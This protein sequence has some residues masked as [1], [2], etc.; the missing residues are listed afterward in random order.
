LILSY[1]AAQATHR[2]PI[3]GW[4]SGGSSC[5]SG[6]DYYTYINAAGF[7]F[8]VPL[9]MRG[10]QSDHIQ[11][12]RMLGTKFKLSELGRP[13]DLRAIVQYD[14][15][16]VNY[17]S[18]LITEN[19]NLY[20][21]LSPCYTSPPN[22]T[23]CWDDD[24][25]HSIDDLEAEGGLLSSIVGG[26]LVWDEPQAIKNESGAVIRTA[27]QVF[28]SMGGA[29]N[30]VQSYKPG[31]LAY[32]NLLPISGMTQSAVEFCNGDPEAM[33]TCYLNQYLECRGCPQGLAHPAQMLSADDYPFE[34]SSFVKNNYFQGLRVQR[35]VAA[36]H[37]PTHRPVPIWRVVQLSQN[38]KPGQSGRIIS[39]AQV[40]WQ[41]YT[42][43][44]YGVK[45]I[46]YWTLVQLPYET[47]GTPPVAYPWAIWG[48]GDGILGANGCTTAK[49]DSVTTLNTELHN[50]GE[51]LVDLDCL[52]TYHQ[53]TIDQ[54]GIGLDVLHPGM[55]Y[56]VVTSMSS[57]DISDDGHYVGST[58]RGDAMVGYLRNPT[59]GE[60][61][62]LIV[63][64]D[65]N[66]TGGYNRRVTVTLS[67]EPSE[68]K[69]CNKVD[70]TFVHFAYGTQTIHVTLGPGDGE[71]FAIGVHDVVAPAAPYGVSASFGKTTAMVSWTNPGDDDMS[72]TAAS[73]DL[74]WSYLPINQDNFE[75]AYTIHAGDTDAPGPAGTHGC[76]D[77]NNYESYIPPGV[78]PLSCNKAIYFAL[79][80]QDEGNNKSPIAY[81]SGTTLGC[82]SHTEVACSFDEMRSNGGGGNADNTALPNALE[83]S[84][85]IPNPAPRGSRLHMDFGVPQKDSGSHL[86]LEIYDIAG[87]NI[88]SL[89]SG[90]A[91]PGRHSQ[92]W[93]MS[94]DD[95]VPVRKGMYYVRLKVGD[96][97]IGHP[98]V[99]F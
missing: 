77:L 80:A 9:P 15:A 40:R 65:W 13:F 89:E 11:L 22:Y 60:G 62:L 28:Q 27:D 91:S 98:I 17:D 71:L 70:G 44:A 33:Y 34:N 97:V 48:Y 83:L 86:R 6:D 75:N 99:L 35:N 8:V 2:F 14:S 76:A 54:S 43:L 55:Y 5:P 68:I 21:H 82:G 26:Y 10:L 36:A 1:S 59:S 66:K 57:V 45:G 49:Y 88:R 51:T 79:R 18:G 95:G 84:G 50:L 58:D 87:R 78:P 93:D 47:H 30:I 56:N 39:M 96:Q 67:Y 72:G 69:R 24:I 90:L 94:N 19:W 20:D 4:G 7:D 92:T 81:A 85:P 37:D 41:V 12:Q 23:N 46:G 38:I 61:Y 32:T 52:A 64:K 31:E 53:A 3:I 73:I 29:A 16:E 74:R 25:Q 63:N 42:A